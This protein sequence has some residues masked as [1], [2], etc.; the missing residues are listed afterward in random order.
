MPS[1][2]L[3]AGA[4]YSSRKQLQLSPPVTGLGR[5]KPAWNCERKGLRPATPGPAPA[6]AP[7]GALAPLERTFTSLWG[8]S[9]TKEQDQ[10]SWFEKA[11]GKSDII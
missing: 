7:E 8:R 2:H 4:F 5:G 11:R 1:A 6:M 9:S 10:R 3:V